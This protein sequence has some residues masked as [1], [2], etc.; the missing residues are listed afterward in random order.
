MIF[1]SLIQRVI[2]YGAETWILGRHQSPPIVDYCDESLVKGSKEL[3]KREIWN[4]KIR[5]L[6]NA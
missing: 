1:K 2:L 5:E 4:L 3:K 6:I